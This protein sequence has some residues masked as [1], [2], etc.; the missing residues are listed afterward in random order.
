[1]VTV[2]TSCCNFWISCPAGV[3]SWPEIWEY[4]ASCEFKK[5]LLASIAW[6]AFTRDYLIYSWAAYLL[7]IGSIKGFKV[8]SFWVY[9]PLVEC[10]PS[11]YNQLFAY[12]R[13]FKISGTLVASTNSL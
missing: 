2:P 8:S 11:E 9:I 10:W 1:M 7:A 6:T 13:A 12:S 3:L 4:L 5:V